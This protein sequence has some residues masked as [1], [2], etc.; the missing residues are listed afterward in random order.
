[1]FSVLSFI[2]P[3]IN[4]NAFVQ[5]QHLNSVSFINQISLIN[6]SKISG[7]FFNNGDEFNYW[8]ILFA[9]CM[10][11]SSILLLRL[12]IQLSSIRKIRSKATLIYKG[13]VNLYKLSE[14]ILPFSFFNS[15]FINPDDYSD[16]EEQEI[17]EHEL[18]HVQQK[19]T[20]DILV[21]EII[22]ILNWYNPFA[23]LIKNA[24]RENLEF[25]ADDAVIKK[26]VNKKNY[27]YLLL[28]VTGDIPS[29]IASS[30]KFLSLKKRILMMNRTKTSAFHL[31]KFVLLVPMITLLLLAFRNS[32]ETV[33]NAFALKNPAAETYT[34]TTLTYSIS[35]ANVKA[36]VL[37]ENDKS[38]L[39]AGDV[40]NLKQIFNEKYRL[41]SLLERNGYNNL[42][43]NA[44]MFW[45]DTA[46][47]KNS[48]SVEIKIDV[49]PPL[50]S[51][52]K[53]GIMSLCNGIIENDFKLSPC[54]NFKVK[55]NIK[56]LV[57]INKI[58][59]ELTSS[60]FSNNKTPF[61]I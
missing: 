21:T 16:N 38:L 29:S 48:F 35:N 44:I 22:C 9:V 23:W 4:V 1:M 10:L 55:E 46:S 13:E 54:S 47:V 2:V 37:K 20:L 36:I 42:K 34:L 26:G 41:K 14:P 31:L 56:C 52:G 45:I 58:V 11:I 28:K 32:K 8:Q 61:L 39:K 53:N 19:H 15:I 43:S 57:A 59:E 18:T 5:E 30:F 7:N 60:C 12:L 33:S 49:E 50:V 3:F 25:I 24:V 17:I 6:T 51:K 27:Q 40:L